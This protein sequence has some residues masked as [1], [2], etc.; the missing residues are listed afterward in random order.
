[1]RPY[2]FK[3]WAIPTPLMQCSWLGERVATANVAKVVEN[4]LRNKTESS[5]GPNAVFRFPLEG[6][7]GAIWKKVA[8]KCCGSLD[9]QRYNMR[10]T[11]I[12]P[13]EHVVTLENGNKIKYNKLLSTLP[14]DL[15]LQWTNKHEWSNKLTY[16]STHVIG[17]G[18]RGISPHDNKCWLYYPENDCNFYRCTVFSLYS[19]N[20]VPNQDIPL[21][22]IRLANGDAGSNELKNG[23]Y[24][25]L[26]FEVSESVHKPVDL[27]TVINV[28]VFYDAMR[29]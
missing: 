4:V 17:I 22:T 9:K 2:N 12:I 19:K 14:L 18:I 21:V 25:S 26:M 1:M 7:T 15:M 13:S 20:N 28:S 6:G 8:N 3:V 16:S 27:N 29:E 24:W 23:P 5:W 11:G 10:V